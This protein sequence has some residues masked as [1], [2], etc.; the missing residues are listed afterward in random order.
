MV[1][2]LSGEEAGGG[3]REVKE[4]VSL[5]YGVHL[6]RLETMTTEIRAWFGDIL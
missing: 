2:L 4:V 1:G 6:D 3:A 5:R